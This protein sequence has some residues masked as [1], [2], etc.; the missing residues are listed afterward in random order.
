VD[1]VAPEAGDP[2]VLEVNTMPGMTPTSL[3]PDAARAA[4]ISF[5]VLVA[6]LIDRAIKRNPG[7]E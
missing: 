5:E 2:I 3:F 7:I 1:F 6:H 4:G